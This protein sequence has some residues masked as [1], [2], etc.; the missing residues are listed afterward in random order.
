MSFW[1]LQLESEVLKDR[2]MS[3]EQLTRALELGRQVLLNVDAV[4]DVTFS[5]D[6]HR[7]RVQVSLVSVDGQLLPDHSSDELWE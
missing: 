3:P 7:Y 6:G 4:N 5:L 2:G 1:E